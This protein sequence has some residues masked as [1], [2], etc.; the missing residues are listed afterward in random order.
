MWWKFWSQ[1]N[2]EKPVAAKVRE[3]IISIQFRQMLCWCL[4]STN[5]LNRIRKLCKS[6]PA[7]T[8]FKKNQEINLY[9]PKFKWIILC[10]WKVKWVASSRYYEQKKI[11]ECFEFKQIL[12]LFSLSK[13]VNT[14]N[15]MSWLW[16]SLNKVVEF[17]LSNS[18]LW[19]NDFQSDKSSSK[20]LN[21]ISKL[22]LV[23]VI[24]EF[25]QD[26]VKGLDS[27]TYRVYFKSHVNDSN[28]KY[29]KHFFSRSVLYLEMSI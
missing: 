20:Y 8:L 26:I 19:S 14:E 11:L 2:E 23:N 4:S 28:F 5:K 16:W 17:Q 1:T 24:T 18:I 27:L 12:F 25:F 10:T 21:T 7:K 13:Y 22:K 6:L 3:M 9:R 15:Q 29:S